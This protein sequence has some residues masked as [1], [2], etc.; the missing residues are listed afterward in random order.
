MSSPIY[1]FKRLA[2]YWRVKFACN[3]QS[4]IFQHENTTLKYS[5][6]FTKFAIVMNES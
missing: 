5:G 6:K 4:G 3:A 2:R 1:C